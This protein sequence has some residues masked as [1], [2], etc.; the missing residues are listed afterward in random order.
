MDY[1][2]Y[3]DQM[4]SEVDKDICS[5]DKKRSML[6]V[7][8]EYFKQ[9]L[10]SSYEKFFLDKNSKDFVLYNRFPSMSCYNTYMEDMG[11]F[12]LKSYGVFDIIL[13]SSFI[14][15]VYGFEKN[16]S[17][18]A[19]FFGCLK[20]EKYD[21]EPHVFLALGSERAL[22][23]LSK[24]NGYFVEKGIRYDDVLALAKAKNLVMFD[25]PLDSQNK[26][27]AECLGDTFFPGYLYYYDGSVNDTFRFGLN[28]KMQI[29]RNYHGSC[30][31]LSD[32]F[33]LSI[34]KQDSFLAKI[35]L[36]TVIYKK[37]NDLVSLDY[38]DYA[39][40]IYALYGKDMELLD[41]VSL[42]LRYKKDFT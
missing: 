28:D 42:K 33:S 26:L 31:S 22:L 39:K 7:K 5:L 6:L 35:L 23:P 3:V 4:I 1:L 8:R 21:L 40:I 38:E 13:L 24:L 2:R 37:N 41:D 17:C 11:S 29:F 10:I 19:Y 25:I 15:N 32:I 14:S 18:D 20:R 36:S 12:P 9:L 16:V 27:K 30:S 34:H